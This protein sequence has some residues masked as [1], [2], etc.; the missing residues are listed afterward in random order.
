M[1]GDYTALFGRI[2]EHLVGLTPEQ[3]KAFLQDVLPT[4]VHD[5]TQEQLK[6]W[7]LHAAGCKFRV[8]QT[9]CA[10]SD[11]C[12]NALSVCCPDSCLRHFPGG[13]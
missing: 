11:S 1:S 4:P 5:F 3:L 10:Y 7:R 13:V 9:L 6:Q 2:R 12:S 8:G